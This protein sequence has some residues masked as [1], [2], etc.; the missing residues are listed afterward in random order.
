MPIQRTDV[1]DR[2]A[3]ALK[4]AREKSGINQRDMAAKLGTNQTAVS[5]IE[6]GS[7]FVRVID[8]V[9][10]CDVLKTDPLEM[11]MRVLDPKSK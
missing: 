3:I 7:Q 4:E 11:L 2:L 10:W 9:A 6:T 1:H 8:V 5:M